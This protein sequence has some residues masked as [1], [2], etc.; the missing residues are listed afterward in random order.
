MH[1]EIAL[2][3]IPLQKPKGLAEILRQGPVTCGSKILTQSNQVHFTK[4]IP[5]GPGKFNTSTRAPT[6]EQAGGGED[7]QKY[8]GPVLS[9]TIQ[10][11]KLFAF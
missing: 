10:P 2:I 7:K 9:W 4:P 6:P 8:I 5:R 1:L 3:Q 11:G